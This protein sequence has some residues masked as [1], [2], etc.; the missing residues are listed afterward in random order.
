MIS[1]NVIDVAFGGIEAYVAFVNDGVYRWRHF[2]YDWP[3]L[4]SY[5]SDQW[6][7]VVS[8]G[9]LPSDAAINRL[10]LR[11]DG[12]LW[13]A[14]TSGLFYLYPGGTLATVPTYTGIT[15][16]IVSPKVQDIVLDHD[17]NLWVATDLGLN[18]IARDDANDIQTFL[19]PAVFVVLSGLR[20]PLD[21]ISPLANADCRSLAVHPSKD[22]LYVGTFG[23]IS[24]YDFSAPPVTATNLSSV[25]VYPNPV[26]TSKGHN[27]IKLGN[28]T[29]PVT[30]EIYDLEGELVDSRKVSADGG[31]AWDLTTRD[32]LQA[33]SG[34]YIVRIVNEK[35][36]VQRPVALIR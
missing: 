11:S 28:L 8:K 7:V 23:G 26:Y 13:I 4:T 5:A 22:I 20:Y 1:G 35:G 15:P 31:I 19:T 34:R 33:G 6:S 9:Q 27:S 3:S 30:V 29:G 16:G 21:V 14:T 10:A 12:R 2:G 36:S 24:T 17:E 32:G 25:Y 18:R